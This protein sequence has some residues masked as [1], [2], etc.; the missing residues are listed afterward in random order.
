VNNKFA[1]NLK[2]LRAEK[3]LSQNDLAKLLGVTQQCVS[4]WELSKTEPTMS[5][6]IKLSEIFDISID[7]LCG[8]K[9]W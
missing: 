2:L 6:L 7:S 3:N 8:K 5:Y 9:E 1:E 4:E